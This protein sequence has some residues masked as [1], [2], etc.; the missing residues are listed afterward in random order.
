MIDKSFDNTKKRIDKTWYRTFANEISLEPLG[1][2]ILKFNGINSSLTEIRYETDWILNTDS[3]LTTNEN[4]FVYKKETE[5]IVEITSHELFIPQLKIIP[6]IKTEP[7][8][9]ENL[10]FLDSLY[11]FEFDTNISRIEY[12]ENDTKVY[13]YKIIGKLSTSIPIS[14]NFP[15]YHKI[16][17]IIN[18]DR[19]FNESRQPKR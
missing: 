5:F 2:K 3:D 18:K 1:S 7:T 13:K 9:K 11:N 10:D 6:I 19:Y 8:Y 17:L 15:T 4:G 16:I 12:E 14:Q